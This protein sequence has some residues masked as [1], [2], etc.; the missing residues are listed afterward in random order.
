MKNETNEK[1]K[2]NK[3]EDNYFIYAAILFGAI[4]LTAI[5]GLLK[6]LGLF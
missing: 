6:M 4:M 3:K 5:V 2:V 1:E